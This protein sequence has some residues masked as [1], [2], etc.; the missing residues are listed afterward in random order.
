MAFE[1]PDAQA[2]RTL[3]QCPR[4]SESHD[5]R[6]HDDHIDGIDSGLPLNHALT[7]FLRGVLHRVREPAL[8]R[9]RVVNADRLCCALPVAIPIPAEVPALRCHEV[10]FE[11][12]GDDLQMVEIELDPGETVIAEAGSMNYM[13]ENISFEAKMGD[14]SQP[15][16]GFL[17]K[18]LSMGKRVLTGESLH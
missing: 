9:A 15:D 11:I 7:F 13:E 2:G 10:D 5:A 12:F 4:R 18:M 6:A 3:E 16:Q 1:N 8:S 17:S 14:G